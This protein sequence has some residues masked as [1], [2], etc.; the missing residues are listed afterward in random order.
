L[1]SEKYKQF[2]FSENELHLSNMQILN[3]YVMNGENDVA[4]Q[5]MNHTLLQ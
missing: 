2:A 3:K 5:L 4:K 1:G